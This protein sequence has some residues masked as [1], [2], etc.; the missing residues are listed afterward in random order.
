[1]Y[2][3]R[4]RRADAVYGSRAGG[5]THF[6]DFGMAFLFC[7]IQ[8]L[9]LMYSPFWSELRNDDVIYAVFTK[10]GGAFEDVDVVDLV[11]F[12]EVDSGYFG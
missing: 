11:Q 7:N 4:V 5:G 2:N 3:C 6:D 1:M 12:G 8:Y 10:S 9:P